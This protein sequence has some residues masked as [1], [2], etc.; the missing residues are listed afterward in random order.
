MSDD[1]SEAE[2][3]GQQVAIDDV[4]EEEEN[5]EN[6][7]EKQ[8]PRPK[9]KAKDKAKAKRKPKVAR[10]PVPADIVALRD[11]LKKN[12]T[13]Y[14]KLLRLTLKRYERDDVRCIPHILD[15]MNLARL[16]KLH[17]AEY[18][19]SVVQLERQ[20]LKAIHRQRR[21]FGLTPVPAETKLYAFLIS[22][23][24]W[25]KLATFVYHMWDLPVVTTG[26]RKVATHPVYVVA[27]RFVYYAA[28]FVAYARQTRCLPPTELFDQ[29]HRSAA[30][31][32][33]LR[34]LDVATSPNMTSARN[35][36]LAIRATFHAMA[37]LPSRP[38]D[39]VQANSVVIEA[40]ESDDILRV[41]SNR[42]IIVGVRALEMLD[43]IGGRRIPI[44]DATHGLLMLGV[45]GV[46]VATRAFW[47]EHEM[48]LTPPY[49][50]HDFAMATVL[51]SKARDDV[52]DTDSFIETAIRFA[53][54]VR[55]YFLQPLEGDSRVTAALAAHAPGAI[56]AQAVNVPEVWEA[57]CIVDSEIRAR[58]AAASAGPS[59]AASASSG[60]AWSL[61]PP[62]VTQPRT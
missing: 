38:Q 20:V 52:A 50:L 51:L 44:H 55:K 39:A 34:A 3:T 35:A 40:L 60:P 48:K 43:I 4:A 32:M 7:E 15:R 47:A 33:Q 1:D 41:L 17:E 27:A 30:A 37:R 14:W 26:N 8:A 6:G 25:T 18:P 46:L 2:Y 22:D 58:R 16:I 56:L 42:D 45:T 29:V 61:A 49:M 54:A 62:P 59:A 13:Q 24:L 57:M 28:A 10:D 31:L 11:P 19:A 9:A 5:A 36:A 12:A 53:K 21:I 23:T